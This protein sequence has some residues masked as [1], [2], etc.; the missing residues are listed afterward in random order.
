MPDANPP[1][2]GKNPPTAVLGYPVTHYCYVVPDIPEAVKF[3]S[4]VMGAGPF[5][6]FEDVEFD[7]LEHPGG[8][9]VFEHS[10][11]LGQWG[12]IAIEL[13]QMDVLTPET[14]ATALAPRTPGLNHVSCISPDPD[15]DSERLEALG[16]PRFLTGKTGD[17]DLRFHSAPLLGHAIELY[18]DNAFVHDFFSALKRSAEGWD[19]REPLRAGL[20]PM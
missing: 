9:A 6:L 17:F 18:R 2:A 13:E 3:W 5:F 15:A 16:C 12:P 11:A 8:P 7:P 1:T 14:L 20:P 10:T 19:G 4:E